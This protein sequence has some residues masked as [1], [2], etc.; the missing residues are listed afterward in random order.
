MFHHF[1]ITEKTMKRME[2]S[3]FKLTQHKPV[4]F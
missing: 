2:V 4:R 3:F 1:F